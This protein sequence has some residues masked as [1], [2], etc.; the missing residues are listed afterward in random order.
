[1]ADYITFHQDLITAHGLM[2]HESGKLILRDSLDEHSQ[3][4]LKAM[5]ASGEYF[6][7]LASVLDQIVDASSGVCQ[8]PELYKLISELL[9][10]QQHYA[11]R[12]K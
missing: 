11:I 2:R 12:N 5:V 3:A 1:M 10:M 4:E 8:H 7:T 6:S 9:Y